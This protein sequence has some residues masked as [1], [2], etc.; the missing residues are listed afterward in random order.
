MNAY[1]GVVETARNYYNSDDADEFYALLWGGE[2]IHIGLYDEPGRTIAQASRRTVEH[3]ASRVSGLG[4][5]SRVLDIGAGYGGAARYLAKAFGCRVTAL[6]LSEKENERNRTMNAE[7]QLDHLVRVVDGSFED[8]PEPRESFD[9]VWS[10]DALLH[11][12]RRQQV[13]REVARVLRPGGE[14]IFTDP[15]QAEDCPAG[16]LQPVL[17]RIHLDSLGS[18]EFYRE[19]CRASG[20][21]ELAVEDLTINLAS[22]YARVREELVRREQELVTTISADYLQ[23]MKAGLDH[24]VEAGKRGYLRW[25]VLHFA[26]V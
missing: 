17:E 3:M 15:M 8:I 21:G 6:N 10:Q 7:Q 23:R 25:G 4:P 19:A 14:F 2:D 22:H 9:L 13:I 12:G 11:S 24:W 18:L 5:Q 1:S 20:M 16:V 26:R